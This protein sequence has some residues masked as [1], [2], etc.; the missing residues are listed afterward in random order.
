MSNR[1]NKEGTVSF[2]SREDAYHCFLCVHVTRPRFCADGIESK[3][4]ARIPLTTG[5]SRM[6]CGLASWTTAGVSLVAE[7]VSR[8][9]GYGKRFQ[10]RRPAWRA[11][12]Q[13]PCRTSQL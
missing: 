8:K 5:C 12:A 7:T 1:G 4:R 3:V 9:D 10:A 2:S 13:M 11:V 6:V